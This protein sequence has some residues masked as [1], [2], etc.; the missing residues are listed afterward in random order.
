[1]FTQS[2][3][4]L[5]VLAATGLVTLMLASTTA[6]AN[7]DQDIVTPLIAGFA[8]GA[9]LNFGSGSRHYQHYQ[10][11]RYGHYR[12]GPGHGYDSHHY[13]SHY[14]RGH[15]NYGQYSHKPRY[16]SSQGGYYTPRHKY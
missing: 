7:H 2:R 10:Y 4:K 12:Q 3:K 9:L 11:Q 5:A 6:R 8:L 14:K 15:N 13:N 1:M 16:S